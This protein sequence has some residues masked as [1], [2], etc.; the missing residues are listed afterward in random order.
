MWFTGYVDEPERTAQRYSRDGSL[1]L[2]GDLARRLSSGAFAFTSRDDDVILMAG[3]R[4]GPLEVESALM[5]HPAVAEAAVIGVPDELRGEVV[6]AFVV[7][8]D[9]VQR[10]DGLGEE[11]ARF[12]KTEYAAHAFPRRVH[13]VDELPKTP[14]GKVQR[15]VLR[16]QRE[17]QAAGIG[18]RS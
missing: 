3:Y 10:A 4:V 6:E 11:I 8:R 14:S 18:E 5:G 9:D 13:L 7:L 12:V 1:Y 16:A 2:T 17:E 15:N